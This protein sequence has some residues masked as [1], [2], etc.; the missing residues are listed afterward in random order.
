MANLNFVVDTGLQVGNL[1]IFASNGD[2]VTS[3]NINTSAAVNFD[4]DVLGNIQFSNT[5]I[6]TSATNNPLILAPNGTGNLV[7]SAGSNGAITTLGGSNNNLLIDPD[8]TGQ[9]IFTQSTAVSM[10]N[11][12]ALTGNLSASGNIVLLNP[13]KLSMVA[14]SVQPKYYIDA[15]AVVFGT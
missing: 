2:I 4:L 13:T 6:S 1:T 14:N 12:L 9:V 5:T 3:G 7:L 10:G 8:G 15:M 11:T